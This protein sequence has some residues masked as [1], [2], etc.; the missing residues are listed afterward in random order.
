MSEVQ[1]REW[2]DFDP[3]LLA[4]GLYWASLLLLLVGA[5][6]L[7]LPF[8][9]RPGEVSHIYITLG[10]Y[11]IYIW[12]LLILG[13]WQS[14]KG[15]HGDVARSGVFAMVLVGLVIMAVNELHLVS[16]TQGI[17]AS[18]LF[19]ILGAVKLYVGPRLLRVTLPVPFLLVGLGWL[20]GLTAPAIL[21][22]ATD[23]YSKVQHIIGYACYWFVAILFLFH[24]LLIRWQRRRNWEVRV[25][26]LNSWWTPW[27]IIVV[28][29]VLAILQLP[30][31]LWSR[32]V[33]MATWYYTPIA[34]ALTIFI[35]ALS[36]ARKEARRLAWVLFV[37]GVLFVM[38]NYQALTPDNLPSVLGPDSTSFVL[39]PIHLCGAEFVV[40]MVLAAW[41]SGTLWLY[42]V[43][44]LPIILFFS[45]QG[46]HWMWKTRHGKGVLF[47]LGAFLTLAGGVG[48]QWWFIR[49]PRKL[50]E[51]P[52]QPGTPP[53]LPSESEQQ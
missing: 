43:A 14:N 30:C 27:V 36:N 12:I 41:C 34:V 1:C 21:L 22:S 19:L 16:L 44:A 10:S 7:I 2:K 5:W 17:V 25:S 20:I 11:E 40:F 42:V 46:A 33:E 18:I 49:H 3:H 15:L 24:M 8:E 29:S 53:D 45:R 23:G 50:K 35:L 39:N 28:L 26:P 37:L 47:L 52:K 13:R 51:I 4:R 38:G 32:Y 6:L 48:I 9:R 31:T